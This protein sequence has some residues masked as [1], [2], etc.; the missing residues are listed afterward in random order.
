MMTGRESHTD[1][2]KPRR[3][4]P[5][6]DGARR[7]GRGRDDVTAV[8]NDH[9]LGSAEGDLVRY[10]AD[11]SC[12]KRC[13]PDPA[14]ARRRRAVRRRTPRHR[15]AAAVVHRSSRNPRDLR[16]TSILPGQ[17]GASWRPASLPA[18]WHDAHPRD[19]HSGRDGADEPLRRFDQVS[20]PIKRK[21]SRSH[22]A[23]MLSRGE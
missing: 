14:H 3:R 6:D 22:A 9:G 21:Y 19:A 17:R 10:G 1:A 7:G 18:P 11:L 2:A 15:D 12:G 8:V 4:P 23:E 16:R 5:D 13:P 20:W